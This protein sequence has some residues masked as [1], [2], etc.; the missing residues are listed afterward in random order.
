[1]YTIASTSALLHRK[2]WRYL[3]LMHAP[4]GVVVT[5]TR[6]LLTNNAIQSIARDMSGLPEF[7]RHDGATGAMVFDLRSGG[8]VPVWLGPSLAEEED[9][10]ALCNAVRRTTRGSQPDR[11]VPPS[12]LPHD[13]WGYVGQPAIVVTR[14]GGLVPLDLRLDAVD[15]RS[16]GLTFVHRDAASNVRIDVRWDMLHSGLIQSAVNVLNEGSDPLAVLDC[17]S[18]ALPLPP[19]AAVATRYAGRW[20]GEMQKTRTPIAQGMI[21]AASFGGRSGFAGA[22]WATIESSDAGEH[23]GDAIAAHLAWS[24]DC[25][26]IIDTDA[27]GQATLL[28]GARLDPGEV[29]LEA[30]QGW[31]SPRAL[32][33]V[34]AQGTAPARQAFH[35]HVIAEA[36]PGMLARTPR[37][38]HLNSWEALGFDLDL[39][40]LIALADDA[41]AIGVERF[42]LDDGWFRGRRDDRS[43]L[44]D[45]TPDPAI[46]PNGLAPLID[47]VRGTGMDFGLWV[48]PEMVSPDSD[49]YRAHPDWCLHVAGQ[50]RPT[51][52]NQLVL[53]LGNPAVGDYLFDCIDAL[54]GNHA[55][56]Y[57]KWDHNRDLFPLAGKGHRQVKALYALLDRLRAAHPCVE[58]ESC[59][60]GGGRVDL[61]ILTRCARVWASDNNDAIDRLRINDGWFDFLPLAVTGNH[62]G[63]SPNPITGRSLPMDFRAKVAMFGHMGVEAN[64]ADMTPQD[65][66]TLT[67]HIALYKQWR[68][69]L[70]NGTLARIAI[71]APGA[72]GWLAWHEGRGIALV[73]QTLSTPSYALPPV[74][75]K[76]L[77]PDRRYRVRL[78][79]DGAGGS[80]PASEVTLSGAALARNGIILPDCRP[81][82]AWLIALDRAD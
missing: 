3:R 76:G 42:V 7:L 77:D 53:D 38:V 49:L 13:G 69:V 20:A 31:T 5:P 43:S 61:E 8:V 73:A 46:F 62:V 65:R 32:F 33:A 9:L 17:A 10:A 67:A 1:V 40:K 41:A 47:H 19:W 78:L 56:A 52:R 55:I 80:H 81:E 27:D 11:P 44:G 58:I 63:P 72:H 70:H 18:L 79:G 24:G 28:M 39:P 15:R 23:H 12:L 48:E 25:R 57:L 75:L 74:R 22:Q 6:A 37:K 30:G 21:G 60:S 64:P 68:A 35:R 29:L 16:S 54:L 59:A 71:D 82:K 51:Q 26:L 45:W 14:D 4:G 50:P 66:D 36:P 2:A 34:S